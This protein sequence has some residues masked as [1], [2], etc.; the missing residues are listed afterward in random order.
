[1]AEVE[2]VATG[3]TIGAL[4]AS[5]A[6]RRGYDVEMYVYNVNFFDPTWFYPQA[7]PMA[8]IAEKLRAQIQYK[9]GSRFAHS[10]EAYIQFIELGG[11]LRF[12]DLS[13]DLLSEYFTQNLP[14]ITGLS[15]T[16]LYRTARDT[17]ENEVYGHDDVRGIPTG[18]FVVLCG[19]D[20]ENHT[21]TVADPHVTNPISQNNYYIVN[22]MRLINA[23]MLGVLT[24]DANLVIFKPRGKP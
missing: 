12:R 8:E 15:A 6:L 2:T 22:T 17:F 16:Y 10:S 19:Q 11:L 24:Y 21:V 23:I 4:L 9:E 3:G 14:I 13:P 7:L 5:H 18:H 1:M 20:P